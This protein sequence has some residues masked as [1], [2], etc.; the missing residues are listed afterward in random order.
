MTKHI[1]HIFQKINYV[2]IIF[3]I[4]LRFQ[5]LFFIVAL[6]KH[7]KKKRIENISIK[8]FDFLLI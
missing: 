3:N 8:Y 6:K 1:I 5:K 4:P 2:L 7:M